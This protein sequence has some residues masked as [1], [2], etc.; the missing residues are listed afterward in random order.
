[1]KKKLPAALATLGVALALAACGGYNPT[2]A[3]NSLNTQLND[4]LQSSLKAAGVSSSVA[5][6]A[7]ITVKCPDSV[8][9]GQAFDCTVSGKASGKSV[10]VPMEVTDND[11][12]A[13]ARQA[14]LDQALKDISEAEAGKTLSN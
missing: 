4:A 9:K 7:G 2:D 8:E 6:K 1:M 5:S 11:E 13:P 12:L 10:T 3:V 14:D